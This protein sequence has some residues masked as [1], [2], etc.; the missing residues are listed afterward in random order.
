MKKKK[1]A[2]EELQTRLT[3]V[4][5]FSDSVKY[6]E[7]TASVEL[8]TK[9]GTTVNFDESKMTMNGSLSWSQMIEIGNTMQALERKRQ[10]TVIGGALAQ[11]LL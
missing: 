4:S 11:G 1:T 3:I 5:W 8:Q 2:D 10:E 6:D 9:Q 7:T